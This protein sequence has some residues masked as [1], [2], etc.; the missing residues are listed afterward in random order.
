MIIRHHDFKL[1]LEDDWL[2][3]AGATDFVPTASAYMVDQTLCK[4]RRLCLICIEDIGPV[5]RAPG[6][7][8]FNAKDGLTA[9]ERAIQILRGFVNG[10]AL[11]PVE[12]L[13]TSAGEHAF[14]L[15]DGLH[16]LYLSLAV[17][18]THVPAIAGFDLDAFDANPDRGIEALC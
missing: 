10:D 7:P 5:R 16:R 6:V 18:F 3:S 17:G 8:Y 2:I 14:E 15:K 1:K 12:L 13:K 9:K 4:D 11:P